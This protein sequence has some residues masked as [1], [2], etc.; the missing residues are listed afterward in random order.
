DWADRWREFH[1]PLVLGRRLT[2]RP[3]WE[4]PPE[5]PMDV[6][7]DPGAAFGTGAHAT[8]RMCLEMMLS[9]PARG[10]FVDLGCGSRVLAIAAAGLR[11][12]RRLRDGG[13]VALL[14]EAG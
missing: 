4:P 12:R 14:R 2:V 1:K 6:V 7:I 9:L 10:P 8:T 13:W 5:T 3:P 11:E